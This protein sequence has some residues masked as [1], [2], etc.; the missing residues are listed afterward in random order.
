LKVESLADTQRAIRLVR[1]R[2]K[3]WNI[4]PDAVGVMGFSAGG[5]LASLASIKMDGPIDAR[6]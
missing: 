1:S 5:E 6:R 4:N 3:E 2:A